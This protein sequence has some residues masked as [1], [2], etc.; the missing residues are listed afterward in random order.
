MGFSDGK[1]Y[2]V[3]AMLDFRYKEAG[4]LWPPI[5]QLLFISRMSDDYVR[6]IL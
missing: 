6:I 3:Y 2:A 5:S 1:G 4:T